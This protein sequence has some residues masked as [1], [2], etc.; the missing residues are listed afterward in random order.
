MKLHN[1][2]TV[3]AT[4]EEVW[5]GLLDM[6]RVA[7]CMPGASLDADP[8]AEVHRGTMRVKLGPMK[9]VYEGVARLADVDED[10]R[11]ASIEVTAKESS[12]QG[13]AS[14]TIVNRLEPRNGAGTLVVADTDLRVAGRQAQF[15]RGM[16]QDVASGLLEEFARRFEQ[17]L[18]RPSLRAAPEPQPE[19]EP[20]PGPEPGAEPEALDLG[21]VVAEP[22]RRY[23][24]VAGAVLALLLLGGS[25]LRRRRRSTI[26][27]RLDH[28][29]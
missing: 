10:T 8:N 17:S 27:L 7:S 19:A 18:R 22:A 9:L 29:W 15:G 12:G 21:R 25:L 2:F 20:P 5:S 23:A 14:A 11:T 13:T 24:L 6:E 3:D 16:M 4:P 26:I 1:E 28:R